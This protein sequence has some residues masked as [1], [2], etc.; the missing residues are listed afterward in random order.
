MIEQ[1]LSLFEI[2][3]LFIARNFNFKQTKQLS[4]LHAA[5]TVVVGVIIFKQIVSTL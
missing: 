4:I 5:Q 3:Y 2:S 1:R